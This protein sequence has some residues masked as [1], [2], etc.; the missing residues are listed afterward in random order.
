MTSRIS[1]GLNFVFDVLQLLHQLFVDVQTAGGVEDHD[2]VAVVFGMLDRVFWRSPPG[3]SVPISNTGTP[4]CSPTTLQLLDRRR[5]VDVAG[6]QQRAVSLLCLNMFG[7]LG[8]SG[9]S[10]RNPASRTS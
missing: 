1:F 4:A 7:K 5:T 10:Y 2:V 3:C 9:W 8:R 6:D